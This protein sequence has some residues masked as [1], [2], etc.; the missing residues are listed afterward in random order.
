MDFNCKYIAVET[1]KS[2]KV[3]ITKKK[4]KSY[5]TFISLQ[6]EQNV[7]CL[8]LCFANVG[9]G[10]YSFIYFKTFKKFF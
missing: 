3:T 4:K 9:I 10:N 1:N 5:H 7:S 8:I 2:Q 6:R